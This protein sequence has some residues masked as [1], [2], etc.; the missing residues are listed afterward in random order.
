MNLIFIGSCAGNDGTG[1]GDLVRF[2]AEELQSV[3]RIDSELGSF[4]LVEKDG[5]E[6]F[7][8]GLMVLQPT[9][10]D[11]EEVSIHPDD[12]PDLNTLLSL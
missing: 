4:K 7:L 9:L 1:A 10:N 5:N 12:T 3:E 8:A 2:K 11:V 6:W